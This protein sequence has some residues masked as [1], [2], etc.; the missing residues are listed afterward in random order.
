[1]DA[2]DIPGEGGSHFA[3]VVLTYRQAEASSAR[4]GVMTQ[5][6]WMLFENKQPTPKGSFVNIKRVL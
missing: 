3:T 5:A 4:Q 6:G 2:C 1:M